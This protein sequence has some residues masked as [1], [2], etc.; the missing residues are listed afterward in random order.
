MTS[1]ISIDFDLISQWLQRGE[2]A[3]TAEL[4]GISRT[5]AYKT[6]KNKNPRI[7]NYDFV[8]ALYEKAL[9]RKMT[10]KAYNEKLAL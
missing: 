4:F 3:E 8:V 5:T 7:R 10:I 2:I 1:D 9:E 6:L